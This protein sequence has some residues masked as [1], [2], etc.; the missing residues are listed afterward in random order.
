MK[1]STLIKSTLALSILSAA[2]TSYAGTECQLGNECSVPN[3]LDSVYYAFDTK[4]GTKFTCELRA[5]KGDDIEVTISSRDDYVFPA[6]TLKADK[7][8]E[9]LSTTIPGQ[10]KEGA[11]RGKIEVHQTLLTTKAEGTVKC[12]PQS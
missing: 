4:Q 6:V 7:S 2:A 3:T 8:G 9:M 5:T 1:L 12:F 11:T 10:F